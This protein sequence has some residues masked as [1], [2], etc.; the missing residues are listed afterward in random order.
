MLE[1]INMEN[2]DKLS[3]HFNLG[4]G[5]GLFAFLSIQNKS[6]P[7]VL[8]SFNWNIGIAIILLFGGIIGMLGKLFIFI[9]IFHSPSLPV[10]TLI[11]IDQAST[12][13]T[14]LNFQFNSLTK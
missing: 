6:Q 12:M 8:F 3:I 11:F 4:D 5:E 14:L 9:R 1:P 10:N 2:D 7:F 13:H